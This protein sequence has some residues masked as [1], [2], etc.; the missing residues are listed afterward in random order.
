MLFVLF[1]I[2]VAFLLVVLFALRTVEPD[3]APKSQ[4]R[5][6]LPEDIARKKPAGPERVKSK[7]RGVA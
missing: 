4:F 5:I 7:A 1:G 6:N 3:R 2:I